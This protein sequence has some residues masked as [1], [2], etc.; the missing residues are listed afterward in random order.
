MPER[1]GAEAGPTGRAESELSRIASSHGAS[2]LVLERATRL[3]SGVLLLSG[4]FPE[5]G[6]VPVAIEGDGQEWPLESLRF[7]YTLPEET[8]ETPIRRSIVMVFKP[9]GRILRRDDRFTIGSP[10]RAVELRWHELR[11][12]LVDLKAFVRATIAP[13][14]AC[15]RAA[16]SKFLTRAVSVQPRRGAM[17]V[18]ET[19]YGLRAGLREHLP[20]YDHSPD[21]PRGLAVDSILAVDDNAFYIEGWARDEEAGTVRV[22]AVSPEGDRAE[23]APGFYRFPRQD[24]TNF[25][26]GGV[27][28]RQE[29]DERLGFISFVELDSPSFLSTGWIVEMENAEGEVLEADCPAVVRDAAVAR[30]RILSDAGR[31]RL[32]EEQLME[33]HIMPALTRFQRH[34]EASAKVDSVTDFGE[35][36]ESPTVS[37]IIPLYKRVDLIEQQLAEFVLDPETQDAE[38]IYVLDSP[39]QEDELLFLASRLFPVY[40][41]PMR[42]AVLKRNVGF[43]NANNAGASIAHGRLLL[44]MNS[45]CLPDRPG[46]LGELGRFYEETPNIGALAPKLLYEDGSIQNAGMYLHRPEGTPVWLDA[47]Y[48][49][50]LHRDFPPA[51]VSRRVP[52][53]SGACLMISRSLYEELGGLRAIFVQGDYEDSD[54]CMRLNELG[55][56]NW[57]YPHVDVFHLEGVSYETGE[58]MPAN[59]YNGWLHTKLWK[60]R[61]PELMARYEEPASATAA[62]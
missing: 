11:R 14:P 32:P 24:V 52:L 7:D 30:E 28:S 40:R 54:L 1:S 37:I 22:T 21:Q 62:N 12:S 19:L 33:H 34:V 8:G 9:K 25:F 4:I 46:W 60:S 45:D 53:L 56:D 51:N 36:P 13:L 3:V 5:S 26:S 27:A 29:V 17:M 48:F 42:V 47:H 31:Q 61:I 58:R 16:A 59:R 2:P 10:E 38:I 15:E 44:L 57:Y 41:V 49:R 39:E 50:G 35:P 6:E 20:R 43:A 18:S 55:R 23:L